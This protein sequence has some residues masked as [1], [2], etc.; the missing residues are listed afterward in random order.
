MRRAQQPGGELSV[1]V[2]PAA[3]R[4]GGE[5]VEHAG[6]RRVV[7][8]LGDGAQRLGEQLPAAAGVPFRQ[9]HHGEPRLGLG[10]QRIPPGRP[11]A[12]DL[13]EHGGTAA[14]HPGEIAFP[15]GHLGAQEG[16][17]SAGVAVGTDFRGGALGPVQVG[18]AAGDIPGPC[19]EDRQNAI[20][21]AH[22]SPRAELVTDRR[23]LLKR[24]DR[25][26]VVRAQFGELGKLRQRDGRP[27]LLAEL[28]EL[29]ERGMAV[30]LSSV[31]PAE[32][33]R[34]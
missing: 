3:Q 34:I 12:V 19:P 15:P 29:A 23:R 25:G 27:P 26:G 16:E 32:H 13:G 9:R 28:T 20:H 18:A 4:R 17:P 30:P 21:V 8:P 2:L 6:E 22:V 33:A 1:V 7:G 14:G 5:R 11:G 10:A 24:G 31:Q